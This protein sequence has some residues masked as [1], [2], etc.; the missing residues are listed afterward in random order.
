V[1]DNFWNNEYKSFKLYQNSFMV[2]KIDIAEE[3]KKL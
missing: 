1:G 3:A 2:D